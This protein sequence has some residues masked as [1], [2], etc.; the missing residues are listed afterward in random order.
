[1]IWMETC[2]TI[3]AVKWCRRSALLVAVDSLHFFHPTKVGDAVIVKAQVN[4]S[5]KTSVEVGVSIFVE[6]LSSGDRKWCNKCYMV[7]VAVDVSGKTVSVPRA[8]PLT[9]PNIRRYHSALVRRH[10]RL[11]IRLS[12]LL[13]G[14]ANAFRLDDW[15]TQ[16]AAD[17]VSSFV[18]GVEEYVWNLLAREVAE[19]GTR[20]LKF[21]VDRVERDE[22]AEG[23]AEGDGIT[24]W[25]QRVDM[26]LGV[27]A[28]K[29]QVIV[30]TMSPL[31]VF[32]LVTLG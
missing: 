16:V 11:Q 4:R 32:R 6:N 30:Q 19:N 18:E 27:R 1:M 14:R 12:T 31:E 13:E 7:F 23:C 2:A 10:L 15:V 29:A 22:K 25:Q 5:F 3:A 24:V 9:Q 17:V 21:D 28:Y 20:D 8:L 26:A